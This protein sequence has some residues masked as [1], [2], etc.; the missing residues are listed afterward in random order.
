MWTR[1]TA[2]PLLRNT[3]KVR[4]SQGSG[5]SILIIILP[6]T[7]EWAGDDRYEQAAV[8]SCGPYGVRTLDNGTAAAEAEYRA[9]CQWNQTWTQPGHELCQG[10]DTCQV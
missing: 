2:G 9:V 1:C 5:P 7:V 8:Y 4:G 10:G 6:G 3:D